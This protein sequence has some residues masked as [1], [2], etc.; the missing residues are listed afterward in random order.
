MSYSLEEKRK[1][2]ERE[3]KLRRRVY[4]NRVL[5]GRMTQAFADREI[6][7]MEAIAEDYRALAQEGIEHGA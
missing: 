5:T 7:I 4:R 1:C 6:A 3:V 2:A